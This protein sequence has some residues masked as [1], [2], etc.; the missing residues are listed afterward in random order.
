MHSR[1]RPGPRGRTPTGVPIAVENG[2]GSS[3]N[4]GVLR[5]CPARPRSC[6]WYSTFVLRGCGS[7][8]RESSGAPDA[9]VTELDGVCS[10]RS[11]ASTWAMWTMP[12]PAATGLPNP[13]SYTDLGDGTVHDDVTCLVWQRDVSEGTCTWSEASDYSSSSP[14][15]GGG[16]RLPTR[17]E[18]ISLIDFTKAPPGPTID[19]TAFPD[20][21]L[22]S[23][24]RHLCWVARPSP[25]TSTSPAVLW[26]S[27]SS[28]SRAVHG[29]YVDE[30]RAMMSKPQAAML[31]AWPAAG[32]ALLAVSGVT[33][34]AAA[35][36]P[37]GRYQIAA[38]EV[39]DTQTH[40]IW[41]QV[42]S[43]ATMSWADAQAYCQGTWRLP[44]ANELQTLIDESQ[45]EPAI[46]TAVFADVSLESGYDYWCSS[47][48][49]GLPSLWW[50]VE[51][52]N[53]N[54]SYGNPSSLARVRCVR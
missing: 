8:G 27:T 13:A 12:N 15:A 45:R 31:C 46:D 42:S 16:W 3:E 19:A 20:M 14:L 51:F 35:D 7:T 53:G 37:V 43:S 6:S 10:E 4:E 11:P 47:P 9:A 24:D 50:Y 32:V 18:L 2:D 36:A 41:Q 28:T 38:G 30:D 52:E 29:V 39:L 23:S 21:R 1:L 33:H 26:G 44:S 22:S 34:R 17:V 25:G 48:V 40:L 5:G 54:N 49:A